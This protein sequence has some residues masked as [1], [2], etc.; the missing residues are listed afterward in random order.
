MDGATIPQCRGPRKRS[1]FQKEGND[2]FLKY[3][4]FE[5]FMGHSSGKTRKLYVYIYSL[6]VEYTHVYFWNF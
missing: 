3:I 1:Q 2:F 5:V 6:Y 4:E